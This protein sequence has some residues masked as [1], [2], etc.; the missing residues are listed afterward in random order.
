MIPVIKRH[1]VNG[2]GGMGAG[3]MWTS[4]KWSKVGV[5]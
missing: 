2:S 3:A 1:F 5:R 4:D